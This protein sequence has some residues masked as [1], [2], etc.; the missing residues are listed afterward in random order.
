MNISH[1]KYA[2]EVAKLGSLNKASETLMTAQ[3]NI[4]RSIKELERDLGIQIFERSAK[5]MFLTA[6]GEEFIAY[7]KLILSQ[8]DNLEATYKSRAPKKMKFSISVPRASYISDA[9]V[10]FSKKLADKPFEVFYKETNSQKTINN[11]LN[12]SYKL[13]I[14]RYAENYD[15]YFRELFEEKELNYET[16]SEFS[17]KLLI[18]ESSPLAKMP[19]IH[20][21][22][23]A[24]LIE[25]AH[26]DPFVPTLPTNKVFKEE[27]SDN[28]S[29]KIFIYER[30]SRFE[31]LSENEKCFMWV[32]PTPQKLLS[33]YAL[34]EKSC[35]E[36]KRIYKDVLIYK[37]SQRLSELDKIFIT[38]L[39]ESRRTKQQH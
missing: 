35:V 32:S 38:E 20:T 16:I 18:S 3:P 36:N 10:E 31:L 37:K 17:Y 19:E 28:V 30:A 24:P 25:I 33:R 13:G 4:S 15:K 5:G 2:V 23:L 29:K 12:S 14:I 22:D 6:D 11:V 34:S 9:F 21:A 8:L 27:L 26:A 7:A 1:M 39:I